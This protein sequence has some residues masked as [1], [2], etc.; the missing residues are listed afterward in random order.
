MKRKLFFGALNAI[1]LLSASAIMAQNYQTMPVQ[2]G[3]TA[4]VIANGIGSSSVTTNNDVD[5]VS[6]A[7]VA[8]DFQLTSTSAAITYGIPADGIINSAVAATPGLSYQLASLSAN[9]SL[10]LAAVNDT[11]TLTFTTPKAAFKLYMLAVSGSSPTATTVNVVVNFTDATS[12]TFSGINVSDWYNGANFA[13]QGIGRINRTNDAL[14]SGSGTNPRLYQIELAI[15]PANQPKQIQSVT[16]TKASG[17]GLPN[18]FAFSADVYSDCAP[19]VLQAPSA[20]TANSALVSWTAPSNAVSYDVYHSTSNATPASSVS[21]TYPGVTGTSTTIGGLNSNTTYYYWVRT[22]CSSAT[23]QSVWSFAGTFKTACST[24]TVPYTENFD[25]TSTGSSTNTNAPSCWAYLESASFAGYG[26]VIASNAYSAPNSYYLYNSTA[27]TGSQML[28]APPTVNLS[29]G[30]KR[31]RF[32]AKSGGTGY[33]LLVGTL[34]NPT[35]PATFT[36]IGSPITLTTTHTQY[37]VNI[38]AGTDLQ[39]AFKHGLGGSARSIYLD[40]IIVQEIPT[41]IEPTAVTPSNVTAY[42]A[43]IGWTAPTPAPGIGYEVYYSTSNTAPTSTTVLNA[44]NSTTSTTVSAPLSGLSAATTYYVW[45]RSKCSASDASEWSIGSTFT[46][47]CATVNAPFVQTFDNAAIPNC[48]T[49]INPTATAPINANL[50]WKFSGS[51]DYG[52]NTANNG[53]PA[54]TYAWVDASSP[55]SGAG[56]NTVQL[57]SPSINLTGLTAPY[58]SFEWYKNHSTTTSTTVSPSTYDNNKLTVEVNDGN[59]WVS[60]FSDTT[61]SNQWRTVEIP[62]AASYIG[63]T[64]Q[65]RFTV[66][67]NVNGNGYFYDD[68]LLDNI[69][70]KQNPNLATS[71]VSAAQNK[72]KVYPNPFKDV[73]NIADMKDVKSVTVMD[74]TGRVVKTIDNPTKQLHLGELSAGLY[75]VTVNF[76]DGSKSTVKAIKQ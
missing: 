21:P 66:D 47:A 54:G 69:N 63:A 32:Y 49:N 41:C 18:V 26:Y 30:T 4:D 27:T 8:K 28:V 68:V 59:G 64:I 40:N 31:V 75:L 53:K 50:L 3:Y 52:T 12:Q 17:P 14:E 46:T 35:D 23:S 34:S 51:G 67:K 19:P 65:V 9:N 25:T 24:F 43:T 73:L 2:S 36:Q 29:S 45:V 58:I 44:T 16:V 11:G 20:I 6:Y 15:D 10:R 60:V 62:L 22:N 37:T 13:I 57:V 70:V 76:K 56:A 1:A 55:Y 72:V 39:L 5:G 74:L 48:W 38:P 42:A 71:E 33:T 7:F 61:N